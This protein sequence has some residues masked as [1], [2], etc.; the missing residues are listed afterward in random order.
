MTAVRALPE[1]PL[2][3]TRREDGQTRDY[4]CPVCG[5]FILASTAASGSV[6][7]KCPDC[8]EWRRFDFG[9]GKIARGS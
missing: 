3:M 2:T 8:N 5:R 7:A 4:H 9:T 6:R 1:S